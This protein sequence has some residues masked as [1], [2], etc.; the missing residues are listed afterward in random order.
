MKA[1][2]LQKLLYVLLILVSVGFY[3]F[4]VAVNNTSPTENIFKVVL[5]VV[6]SILG[7]F[8]SNQRGRA[9][10]S[11]YERQYSNELKEAFASDKKDRQKLVSATRYYNENKID[12]ALRLLDELKVKCRRP[13]DFFAVGLFS[14][15]CFTDLQLYENAIDEYE[16]LLSRRLENGTIY[17]NLGHIYGRMGKK[18]E[19]VKYYN[20]AISRY[21][22]NETAY[23]N[24]ANMYFADNEFDKAIEFAN[25]ALQINSKQQQAANLLAIVYAM[26]EDKV[27]GDKYFHLAKTCG[28]DPTE[29]KKAIDY[30]KA[31]L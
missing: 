31:G 3:I 19:A 17:N 2:F 27:N 10:L 29:L 15:L 20:Q 22:E 11:V 18:E 6:C 28:S 30:Y 7:M 14:G 21:P 24:M 8:R 13:D 4:D 23:V 9:S 26:K 1:L 25:K 12:K 16:Q 5:V